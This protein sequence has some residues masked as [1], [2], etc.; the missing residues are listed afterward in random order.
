MTIHPIVVKPFH[1]NLRVS[2]AHNSRDK[3]KMLQVLGT[4]QNFVPMHPVD[5]LIFHWISEGFN[6]L[7]MLD[8]ML[9]APQSQQT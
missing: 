8:E 7:L 9:E 5:V 4:F 6:V 1:L 3:K 2:T